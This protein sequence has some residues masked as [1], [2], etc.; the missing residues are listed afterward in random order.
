M[1]NSVHKH[2]RMREG[3]R[4]SE[5]PANVGALMVVVVHNRKTLCRIYFIKKTK[6]KSRVPE[7]D[8][9]AK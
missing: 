2:M 3:N 7:S 9:D 4:E 1:N 6:I 5:P 8:V